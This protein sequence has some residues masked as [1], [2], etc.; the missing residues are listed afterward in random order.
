MQSGSLMHFEVVRVFTK[1]PVID[2]GGVDGNRALRD[3]VPV[4]RESACSHERDLGIRYQRV[5]EGERVGKTV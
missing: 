4:S 2:G 5:G 1:A 3:G